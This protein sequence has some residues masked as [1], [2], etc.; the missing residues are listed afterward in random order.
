[1]KGSTVH[2]GSVD[3]D[4]IGRRNGELERF[5][6]AGSGGRE[7]SGDGRNHWN[8]GGRQSHQSDQATLQN[9][10]TSV[11]GGASGIRGVVGGVNEGGCGGLSSEGVNRGES[12]DVLFHGA[13]DANMNHLGQSGY[14][15]CPSRIMGQG[16]FRSGGPGTSNFL[17]FIKYIKLR[18]V[19]MLIVKSWNTYYI[20]HRP[21]N[22]IILKCYHNI[23]GTICSI[24]FC[25]FHY[26]MY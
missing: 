20:L 22:I 21:T 15:G 9:I 4:G 13:M 24:F 23:S 1:M 8:G 25:C 14:Y 16:S 3:G 10:L 11:S 12:S 7:N 5:G 26:R 19:P 17:K 2:A 6:G 18:S